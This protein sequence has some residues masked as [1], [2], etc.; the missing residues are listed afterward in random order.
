[1]DLDLRDGKSLIVYFSRANENYSVGEVEVGNTELLATALKGFLEQR[2]VAV[3][4]FK[5]EP[6]EAYPESYDDAVSQATNERNMDERPE[7]VGDVEHFADYDVV[8]LGY[9][10]W[11]GDLPMIVYNFIEKHEFAGKVVVP[12]CTHEGSGDS[13][14]FETLKERLPD[15][16]VLQNGFSITGHEA[17]TE[18]GLRSLEPWLDELGL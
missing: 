18:D 1:M 7:Y 17:R 13:G 14:S 9:P 10:I 11:W 16:D 8:Y 15:A 5:I 4:S 6:V 12:F 3:D 2:E